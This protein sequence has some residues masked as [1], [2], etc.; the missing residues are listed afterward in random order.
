MPQALTPWSGYVELLAQAERIFRRLAQE[1]PDLVRCKLGCDDC[2]QA[3]FR[4]SLIEA[5]AV[6]TALDSLD[7]PARRVIVRRAEKG[8]IEAKRA[9]TD[10]PAD[11]SAAALALAKKRLRCP[12]L[13]E[14][15]CTVYPAQPL[16][17]RLYGL[18]TASAGQSHTCPRSGF[19][20]GESYPTV[21]LDPLFDRLAELSLA[22]VKQAGLS[23]MILAPQPVAQAIL[24]D[25]PLALR[26]VAV[27]AGPSV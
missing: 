9:F 20:P 15:G 11:P 7:R 12:L 24:A 2:C 10:L 1:H 13:D 4:L 5:A 21:N 19:E 22:L 14:K 23:E 6:K 8:A 18:P 3:P 25:Y 17:C 26:P 16:T 27:G